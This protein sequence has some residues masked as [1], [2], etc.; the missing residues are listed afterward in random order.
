MC[1]QLTEKVSKIRNIIFE[2]RKIDSKLEFE[3]CQY[4]DFFLLQEKIKQKLK[5]K[6]ATMASSQDALLTFFYR[7]KRIS[8]W[9]DFMLEALG[10]AKK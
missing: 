10:K 2:R 9:K 8:R 5:Y 3:K 6:A 7:I 1:Q 4:K